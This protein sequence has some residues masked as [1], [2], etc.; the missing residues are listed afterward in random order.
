MLKI[1]GLDTNYPTFG[2]SG[3]DIERTIGIPAAYEIN[4]IPSPRN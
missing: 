3:T 2:E 4:P 1:P